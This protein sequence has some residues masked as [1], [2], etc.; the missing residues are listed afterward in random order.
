MQAKDLREL[1]GLPY[2]MHWLNC[3]CNAKRKASMQGPHARSGQ[4]RC[5][6]LALSL[7]VDLVYEAKEGGFALRRPLEDPGIQ[8]H[9]LEDQSHFL[10]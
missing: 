3:P 5:L 2:V 4:M 7:V 9:L 1:D 6:P 10:P 8:Q